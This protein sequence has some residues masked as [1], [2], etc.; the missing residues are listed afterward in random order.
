[1]N[2]EDREL[3]EE[4]LAGIKEVSQK[5]DGLMGHFGVGSGYTITINPD[6]MPQPPGG[7][8]DGQGLGSYPYTFPDTTG[9]QP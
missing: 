7:W 3:L 1:M 6:P 4:I 9:G 8:W 2:E 5:L